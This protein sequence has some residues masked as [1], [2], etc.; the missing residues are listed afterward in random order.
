MHWFGGASYL[1]AAVVTLVHGRTPTLAFVATI[2][3]MWLAIAVCVEARST[4]PE[5]APANGWTDAPSIR[6]VETVIA[7][8]QLAFFAGVMRMGLVFFSFLLMAWTLLP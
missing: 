6:A 5:V 7:I 1:T 4:T 8:R 2:L 3:T